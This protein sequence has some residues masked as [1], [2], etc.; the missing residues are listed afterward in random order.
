MRKTTDILTKAKQLAK[1]SHNWAD[2]SNAL[3]DPVDGL[4]ATLATMRAPMAATSVG[5]RR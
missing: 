1:T 5:V 2:L 4:I 3:F